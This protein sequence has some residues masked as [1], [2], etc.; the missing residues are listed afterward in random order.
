MARMPRLA[1][2]DARNAT[3]MASAISSIM[4]GERVRSSPIAPVRNG[5][6]PQTNITVPRTGET[7]SAQAASGSR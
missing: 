6:P 7:Q 5:R 4:P 1:P 3:V 2:Q